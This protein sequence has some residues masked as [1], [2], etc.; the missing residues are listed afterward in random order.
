MATRIHHLS[1]ATMCPY[2]GGLL[3]GGGPPWAKA[4]LCAHVLL[5]E[6]DGSLVLVDTGFGRGDVANPKR[7][8]Q[9]FRAVVRPQL[10]EMRTAI[11]QVE[12]LGFSP[13]DVR[14]VVCTHLD[15]DHAGGLPDFP[16][17]EVHLWHPELEALQSP[18]MRERPRYLKHHFAHGPRWR[19][20]DVDGD[21]WMGF[22]AVRALPGADHEILIVPLPGHSRGHSAIAV[23][24]GDGWLLH[25]GDAYF[26]RSQVA[27]PAGCPPGLR[28]FQ[29]I[30]G[31]ERKRR[32]LN[33]ERLRELNERR[34]SEIRMFSAHDVDELQA[35]RSRA[36]A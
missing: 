23:A 3:G 24:E 18:S 7:L 1:C 26:H 12:A 9:P 5:V 21:E 31:L 17:A 27:T 8:G 33:E 2:G 30:V 4:E 29:A 36:A 22:E 16:G 14:H 20:H 10:S 19:P 13:S 28:A 32:L 6:T 11:R 34:G 25:C 35:L 15:V